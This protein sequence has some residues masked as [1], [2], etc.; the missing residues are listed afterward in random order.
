LSPEG[1][2]GRVRRAIDLTLRGG[3]QMKRIDGAPVLAHLADEPAAPAHQ[4]AAQHVAI[5]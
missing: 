2:D 5:L 1:R 4:A 3:V